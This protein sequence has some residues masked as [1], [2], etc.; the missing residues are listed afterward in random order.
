M[1]SFMA[2]D[3][4]MSFFTLEKRYKYIR[5]YVN[6]CD[7]VQLQRDFFSAMAE[8]GK[9]LKICNVCSSFVVC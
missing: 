8:S 1:T 6:V 2:L 3:G 5:P 7:T 9:K 4:V